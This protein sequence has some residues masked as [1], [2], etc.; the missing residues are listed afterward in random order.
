V[1]TIEVKSGKDSTVHSDLNN[2]I[3]TPDYHIQ[4]AVVLNNEREV[5]VKNGIT[6]L[7][8]YYCMFYQRDFVLDE[9][10]LVIPEISL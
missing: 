8:V 5:A 4:K 9:E 10:G 2:F 1:L 7:P 6:Y 3:N